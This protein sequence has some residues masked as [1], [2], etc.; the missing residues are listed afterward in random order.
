MK[1]AGSTDGS[2]R[3]ECMVIAPLAIHTAV[4]IIKEKGYSGKMGK[5]G[6]VE[7]ENT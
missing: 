6:R 3:K 1:A 5:G 7:R 4:H 2:W